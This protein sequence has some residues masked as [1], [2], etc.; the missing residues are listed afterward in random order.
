MKKILLLL[1][2]LPQLCAAQLVFDFGI[3]FHGGAF[4]LSEDKRDFEHDALRSPNFDIDTAQYFF[5][6]PGDG[7]T[8]GIT[9]M[10]A[11]TLTTP[12]RRIFYTATAR[13]SFGLAQFQLY[14]P[15][16]P[17]LTVTPEEVWLRD[18]LRPA[19]GG[20]WSVPLLAHVN[21]NISPEGDA[22]YFGLGA[23]VNGIK[24]AQRKEFNRIET[25]VVADRAHDPTRLE[26]YHAFYRFGIYTK[27]ET[28]LGF[29]RT[30][31]SGRQHE[32]F[33]A[34][35]IGR[36]KQGSVV[37]GYFWRFNFYRG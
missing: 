24:V 29:I 23:S 20:I 1:L 26:R 2:L 5:T 28:Q 36:G 33:A 4:R 7:V 21:V 16:F 18:S 32:F 6:K 15:T 31:R 12:D 14:T 27:L 37:I 30:G 8:V 19:R 9:L 11:C 25:I 13:P 22:L 17:L 34:A 10:T 3:G 35:S